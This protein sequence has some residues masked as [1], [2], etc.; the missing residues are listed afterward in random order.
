M[1]DIEVTDYHRGKAEDLNTALVTAAHELMETM[2]ET[3]DGILASNE[4]FNC[5]VARALADAGVTDPADIDTRIAEA[6]EAACEDAAQIVDRSADVQQ[7]HSTWPTDEPG[8]DVASRAHLH[9]KRILEEIAEEIRARST[10]PDTT[11]GEDHA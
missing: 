3:P 1:S 5:E 10:E 8:D 4:K 7:Q 11:Q 6:V 2:I 9:A